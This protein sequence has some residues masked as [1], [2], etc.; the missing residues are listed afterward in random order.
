MEGALYENFVSEAFVKQE[1]PLVYYKK[2][3]STLEGDFFVRGTNELI[4]VEVKSNSNNSKSLRALTE[5]KHYPDIRRG[6]KLCASNIGNE[7][8]TI[9]FPYFCTFML[10]KFLNSYF[11]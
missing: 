9:T 10:K 4:P 1:L 8:N 6:I 7:N 3:N 11:V 5:S 2:D